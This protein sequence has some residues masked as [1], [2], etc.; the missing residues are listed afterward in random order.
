MPS[1]L[2]HRSALVVVAA[3]AGGALLGP[4]SASAA[5]PTVTF[6]G[7]C[8]LLG[9]GASSQPDTT[10]VTVGA[11]GSVTFVNHL[12]QDAQLTI[13]GDG[14]GTIAKDTAVPVSFTGPATVA[15]VPSCLLGHGSAGSVSVAVKAASASPTAPVTPTT[16]GRVP[17]GKP[18]AGRSPSGSPSVPPS[19]SPSPTES[20]GVIGGANPAAVDPSPS[21]G[22]AVATIG[23]ATPAPG[24]HGPSGL[25]TLVSTICVVGV[26]IAAIR[27]I[28]A[29]RALRTVTA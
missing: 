17:T 14:R 12:S 27:V 5:S 26:S 8:G 19:D 25:L 23:G 9:V 7:N 4:G 16:A 20:L 3:I 21:A 13:N 24:R 18:S 2:R 6:N 29:Q 1:S 11:G 10:S 15:L 28:I 22:D